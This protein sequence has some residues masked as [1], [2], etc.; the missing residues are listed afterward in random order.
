MVLPNQTLAAAISVCSYLTRIDTSI[1]GNLDSDFYMRQTMDVLILSYSLGYPYMSPISLHSSFFS[2]IEILFPETKEKF[3]KKN[4]LACSYV[5]NRLV[6]DTH[7][8]SSP[9]T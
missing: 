5:I 9:S 7:D 4:I 6:A 1:N 2:T 3:L 8:T